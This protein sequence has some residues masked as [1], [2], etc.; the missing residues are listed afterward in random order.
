MTP[1]HFSRVL[2]ELSAAGL[3]EV[4]GR[5][6]RILDLEGLARLSRL[7]RDLSRGLTTNRHLSYHSAAND[8]GDSDERA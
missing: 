5:T 6:V 7:S 4:D 2:H 3:I 8:D 1:E